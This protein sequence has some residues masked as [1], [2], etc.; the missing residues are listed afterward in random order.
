[1][2]SS[3][4]RRSTFATIN[5][6]NVAV[7]TIAQ[8]CDAV[9]NGWL[10]MPFAV[11]LSVLLTLSV[12]LVL[13]RCQSAPPD[14]A[15]VTT[16]QRNLFVTLWAGTV[17]W[18]VTSTWAALL[19]RSAP[20]AIEPISAPPQATGWGQLLTWLSTF[21]QIVTI[22]AW[23]A[24]VV[25]LSARVG[26]RRPRWRPH[27][28]DLVFAVMIPGHLA[29]IW[30]VLV[31][32]DLATGESSWDNVLVAVTMLPILLALLSVSTVLTIW[33]ARSSHGALLTPGQAELQIGQWASLV[34]VGAGKTLES[35]DGDPY[36]AVL[37]LLSGEVGVSQTAVW[38]GVA[39]FLVCYVLLVKSLRA[40]RA[41]ARDVASELVSSPGPCTDG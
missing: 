5:V 29:I 30:W 27:W 6:V 24:L 21:G 4:P 33:T 16:W 20:V 11:W 38:V 7:A 10:Q 23:L 1:M 37:V 26:G 22:I 13:A 35:M 9:L 31:G 15:R 3:S 34:A 19:A 28:P 36:S 12:P 41:T 32:G 8:A 14:E 39:G 17:L 25:H 18:S 2:T 40:R